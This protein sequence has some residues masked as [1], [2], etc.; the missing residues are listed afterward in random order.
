MRTLTVQTADELAVRWKRK[1]F[2]LN[3]SAKE[4]RTPTEA[5]RLLDVAQAYRVCAAELD[6]IT[7]VSMELEAAHHGDPDRCDPPYHALDCQGHA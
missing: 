6:A 3:A 1:A 7:L 2:D 5:A 4:A